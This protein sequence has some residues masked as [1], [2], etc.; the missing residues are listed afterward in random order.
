MGQRIEVKL[1]AVIGTQSLTGNGSWLKRTSLEA[2]LSKPFWWSFVQTETRS[3]HLAE[4]VY[5]DGH[6]GRLKGSGAIGWRWA[7]M[8][9][10]P[11]LPDASQMKR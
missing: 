3:T 10:N 1:R 2:R 8:G 7:I 4:I 9:R 6:N 11:I 5:D